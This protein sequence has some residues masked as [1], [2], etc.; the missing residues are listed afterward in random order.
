MLRCQENPSKALECALSYKR[1][2][3]VSDKTTT[4]N[5]SGINF[6]SEDFRSA[7]SVKSDEGEAEEEDTSGAM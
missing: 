3:L 6:L 5:S 7:S 4:P 2:R 1:S